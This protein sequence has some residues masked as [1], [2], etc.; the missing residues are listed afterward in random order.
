M[1]I[2]KIKKEIYAH[3]PEVL[4]LVKAGALEREMGVRNPY[5]SSRLNRNQNGPYSIRSFKPSDVELLNRGMWSLG[6]KLLQVE[7]TYTGE[8][9]TDVPHLKQQLQDLFIKALIQ[10]A[11][12][13]S[14][15]AVRM[16]MLTGANGKYRKSF[17]AADYERLTLAVRQV[18]ITLLSTEFYVETT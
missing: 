4:R 15:I 1:E 9:D 10:D 11:L 3:L 13:I 14:E 17:T 2:P 5:I 7:L 12:G 18:G 6:Q 16:R 8:R